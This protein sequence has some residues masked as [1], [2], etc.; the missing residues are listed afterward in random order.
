MTMIKPRYTL[1]RAGATAT[2][3]QGIAL[4]NALR[5]FFRGSPGLSGGAASISTDADNALSAGTDGGIYA[6]EAFAVLARFAEIST[7]TTAKTQARQN[8]D[9]QN[10]DCGTFN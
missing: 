2:P 4:A 1:R 3:A 6:P 7:D 5:P 8:L 10:I 9:L